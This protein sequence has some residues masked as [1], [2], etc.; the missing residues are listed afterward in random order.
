MSEEIKKYFK[1]GNWKYYIMKNNGEKPL[2]IG[3]IRAVSRDEDIIMTKKEKNIEL[4]SRRIRA[5]LKKKD[6]RWKRTRESLKG[7][8]N[9]EEKAVKKA[10]LEMD[11][12]H[13]AYGILN[14]CRR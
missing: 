12:V 14:N 7:R 6:Y 3:L 4:S 10:D 9:P 13:N 8:Q 1:V 11:S 5:I 2:E